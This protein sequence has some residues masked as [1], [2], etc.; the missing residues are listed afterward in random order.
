MARAGAGHRSVPRCSRLGAL[1]ARCC[2]AARQQRLWRAGRA[3]CGGIRRGSGSGGG[4]GSS[5]SGN[6]S[7]GSG[8]GSGSGGGGSGQPCR[9]PPWQALGVMVVP[10]MMVATG[11]VLDEELV[12]SSAE[13]LVLPPRR[14]CQYLR[15]R[16]GVAGAAAGQWRL[17]AAARWQVCGGRA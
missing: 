16:E 12:G 15:T 4:G 17:A 10:L 6:G 8:S 13:L 2:A 1:E 7:G 11:E 14:H 5:G 9:S 3:S